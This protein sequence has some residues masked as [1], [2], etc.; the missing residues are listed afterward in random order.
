[1]PSLKRLHDSQ[2]RMD[3]GGREYN[4]GNKQCSS[5]ISRFNGAIG[6][7]D[8]GAQPRVIGDAIA[9]GVTVI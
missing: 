5:M 8:I 9:R 7:Y 4:E 2:E 6:W 1:M 3:R